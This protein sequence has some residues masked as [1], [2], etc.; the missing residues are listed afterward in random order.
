MGS[1]YAPIK[2]HNPDRIHSGAEKLSSMSLLGFCEIQTG[3]TASKTYLL[4]EEDLLYTV[5]YQ[6]F[7][8]D[9]YCS[10]CKD[11]F[12]GRRSTPLGTL[13]RRASLPLPL[14]MFYFPV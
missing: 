13:L 12:G 2:L 7:G 14:D 11:I 3:I 5:M 1:W 9:R 6:A 8:F 10:S 4:V